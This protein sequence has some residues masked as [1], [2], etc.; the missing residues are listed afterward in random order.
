MPQLTACVL[1]TRHDHDCQRC[2]AI[3]ATLPLPLL[4]VLV[5]LLVF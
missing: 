4:L 5:L 2:V 1:L 3:S